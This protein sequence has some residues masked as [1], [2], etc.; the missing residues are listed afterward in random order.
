MTTDQT[1]R[2]TIRQM[3]TD[4]TNATPEQREAALLAAAERAAAVLAL[5]PEM[6]HT[7]CSRGDE[8]TFE[9]VAR[10]GAWL[11]LACSACACEISIKVRS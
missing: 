7:N 8:P 1:M 5:E 11:D 6:V 9:V 10:R 4:W 2:D 3:L